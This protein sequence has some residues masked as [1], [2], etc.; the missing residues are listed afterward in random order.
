MYSFLHTFFKFYAPARKNKS[1][2]S[3]CFLENIIFVTAAFC[4]FILPGAVTARAQG[5]NSGSIEGV[6]KDPTGAAVANAIRLNYQA[7]Q[8]NSIHGN[9][10]YSRSR[11]SEKLALKFLARCSYEKD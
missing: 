10:S 6:I 3:M 9:L 1:F 4:V 7:S 11:A 5:A 8:A 2:V